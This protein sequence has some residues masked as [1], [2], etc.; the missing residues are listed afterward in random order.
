MGLP[1]GPAF[2]VQLKLAQ[3]YQ[4]EG[5]LAK[6]CQALEAALKIDPVNSTA[7]YRLGLVHA[8]LGR[9]REAATELHRAFELMGRPPATAYVTLA[10]IYDAQGDETHRDQVLELAKRLPDGDKAVGLASAR[11]KA[12]HGDLRG[13]ED[14]LRDL[15]QRYP[16]DS[17]LWTALGPLL[18]DANRSEESLRALERAQQLSP[19]DPEP[20]F[21]AARVLH[22]IGRDRDALQQCRRALALAPG[23]DQARTLRDEILRT[24][25]GGQDL[26]LYDRLRQ[27]LAAG[28]SSPGNSDRHA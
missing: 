7:L 20:H 21:F 15:V 2:A 9:Y 11:M 14:L 10:E 28:A 22:A 25:A 18:A 4:D 8:R 3:I 16:D 1:R 5:D 19:D 23:Y 27:A 13:A 24:L 26:H 6:A 12:K 17:R